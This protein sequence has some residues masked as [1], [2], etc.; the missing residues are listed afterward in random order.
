MKQISNS[1]GKSL[2]SKMHALPTLKK[3]SF[4]S[5]PAFTRREEE[6]KFVCLSREDSYGQKALLEHI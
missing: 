6:E 3:E 4:N 5:T 1:N 2:V